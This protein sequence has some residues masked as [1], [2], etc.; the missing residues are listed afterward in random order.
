[1]FSCEYCGIFKNSFF[2]RT[3]FFLLNFFTGSQ[4]ETVSS[5]NC[6]AMKTLKCSFPFDFAFNVSYYAQ[7]VHQPKTIFYRVDFLVVVIYRYFLFLYTQKTYIIFTC[8]NPPLFLLPLKIFIVLLP[9]SVNFEINFALN[10][11]TTSLFHLNCKILFCFLPIKEK[12]LGL[13]QLVS[14]IRNMAV[15]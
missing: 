11:N 15:Y 2:H 9:F 14:E 12:S 10:F 8:V 3:A 7:N 5:I 13:L 4:K 6:S 1:M